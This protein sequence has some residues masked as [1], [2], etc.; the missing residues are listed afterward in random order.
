M[1]RVIGTANIEDA[2][3]RACALWFASP[4]RCEIR[5][6]HLPKPEEGEVQIRMLYSGISRGTESL[7]FH[8]RVPPSEFES[9]RGPNMSGAFP[10]PVKYGYAAVGVVE[11]GDASLLGRT[12]FCLYPH[13]ERFNVALDAAVPLPDGLPAAR[14][15]L[16]ANM[17]T[18]LNIVWD[19]EILPG[20]RVA[21]FGA[22]VVGT[23]VAHLARA[24]IGTEVVLIDPN[25]IR[26]PLAAGLGIEFATGEAV[27]GDFDVLV[28]ASGSAKALSRA[29]ELAGHEARIVEASWHGDRSVS[30]P[31]GGAFHSRRL[32]IASSQVGNLPAARRMRW[33][34]AR[35]LAKALELL[36]DDRLDALISGEIRFRDLTAAYP[37][38]LDDPQTLCHRICYTE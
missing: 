2:V 30:L 3:P 25:P 16:T 6:E 15:V 28:N 23:L 7:I 37:A 26:A 35:R 31:L 13:Q 10:F 14:A 1:K 9:M 22:G 20:D 32:M 12:V 21:V 18:A 24:I 4:G 5:A 38:I 34:Y 19:A 29:I 33:T 8:G 27:A 11:K 17:E 36:R